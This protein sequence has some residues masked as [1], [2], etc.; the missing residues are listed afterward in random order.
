MASQ[1][2]P[3]LA[4]YTDIYDSFIMETDLLMVC[5]LPDDITHPD[6]CDTMDRIQRHLKV[7]RI[8][9]YYCDGA[10]AAKFVPPVCW[11]DDG[12]SYP[13]EHHNTFFLRLGGPLPFR[14]TGLP[15]EQSRP[16]VFSLPVSPVLDNR[17]NRWLVIQPV[18]SEANTEYLRPHMAVWRG[19]GLDAGFGNAGAA[20]LLTKLYVHDAVERWHAE[21][22]NC[23][24]TC[25]SF[26]SVHK[27]DI[28]A[29]AKPP[30]TAGEP[31][32]TGRGRGH[33][34]NA[35]TTQRTS[36][37]APPAPVD[38]GP[39]QAHYGE[40]FIITICTAPIGQ[41][42]HCFESLIPPGA[43]FGLPLYP[44]RFCGMWMELA[45]GLDI[46]RSNEKKIGPGLELV[47]PCPTTRLRGLKPGATL[48]KIIT[49]LGQ[50]GQDN[51][52]IL[53]GYLHRSSG[54]DS[55]ILIT[56]GPRLLCTPSLR[57]LS[58]SLTLLEESD[59]DDMKRLRERYCI[60]RRSLG[61]P[62]APDAR[63][64]T[65]PVAT[66]TTLTTRPPHTPPASFSEIV[67]SLP[68]GLGEQLRTMFTDVV[69]QEI[70]A[71]T[72]VTNTRVGDLE[73]AHRQTEATQKQ[74]AAAIT[75]LE[76]KQDGA[77]N[78]I[79]DLA[80]TQQTMREE[81]TVA[82][83]SVKGMSAAVASH[84]QA[85]KD[86][87]D[88]LTDQTAQMDEIKSSLQTLFKRRHAD[89]DEARPAPASPGHGM[90]R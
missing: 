73:A 16:M 42:S 72:R 48:G 9:N 33:G 21:D 44:I 32:R 77:H 28:R 49:A 76:T 31:R 79:Q 23:E 68:G 37:P 61:L 60:F 80:A 88:F 74:H 87:N 69:Q 6:F 65:A 10:F 52:G 64:A 75:T 82:Q 1:A 13:E 38:H 84:T 25:Y 51:T 90:Q 66:P 19:A 36:D 43:A 58:S 46:F 55:C 17:P 8:N 4:D 34:R 39:A 78:S 89:P 12:L 81:V 7:Y 86:L 27:V 56:Q 50:D 54:G 11:A 2:S 18:F 29:P 83:A 57:P 14:Y 70:A 63:L 67:R 85:W 30:Q 24:W 40:L 15:G 53:G 26:L 5:Y 71:A 59:I 45:R 20:L 3:A 41:L 22:P 62:T 35:R 47:N